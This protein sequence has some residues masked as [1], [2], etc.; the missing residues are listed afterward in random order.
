MLLFTDFL[1][2][3]LLPFSTKIYSILIR[4]R[5]IPECRV[6][7]VWNVLGD[8]WN[9]YV[10]RYLEWSEQSSVFHIIISNKKCWK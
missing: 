1:L 7:F 8:T 4:L 5:S 10:C 3:K 9:S 6:L 2:S